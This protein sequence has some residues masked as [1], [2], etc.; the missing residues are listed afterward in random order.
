MV[1]SEHGMYRDDNGGDPDGDK[2]VV[3]E[4]VVEN[5]AFA[6]DHAS[7]EF[8]EERHQHEDAEHHRVVHAVPWC[9]FGVARVDV[10]PLFA[11]KRTEK[12]LGPMCSKV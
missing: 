11:W 8:V 4:D 10:E 2:D 12:S 3:G 5:V 6:V 7:I 1:K 9:S